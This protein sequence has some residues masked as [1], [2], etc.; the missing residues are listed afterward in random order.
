MTEKKVLVV[1]DEES[2]REALEEFLQGE[3]YTVSLAADGK[4]ALEM[5]S[6][7][8]YT[9]VFMDIKMPGIDGIQTLRRMKKSKPGVKVIVITGLP[10]EKTLER[11]M[12]VSE[13]AVEG[14]IPKPFKPC[15][16]RQAL[17]SLAQGKALPS[18]GLT[19]KQLEVL[20]RVAK[21]GAENASQAL[22]RIT[23]KE[24]KVAAHTA[25]VSSIAASRRPRESEYPAAGILLR[26][27]GD[28]SGG[29]A[30]ILS[31]ESGQRLA[32]ILVKRGSKT[33]E[34]FDEKARTILET[35]GNVIATSF[36]VAIEK[37]LG[38][39]TSA[40]PCGLSFE[41]EA[42]ILEN[43]AR[44]FTGECEHSVVLEMEFAVMGADVS[45][46]II[47]MPDMD[48]LKAIFRQAG[49]FQPA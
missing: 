34:A 10:D 18:F 28:I 47:L 25:K 31:W 3:G 8:D 40:S 24:T 44:K 27:A 4:K 45:G 20:S 7:A 22:S 13:G 35:A 46:K 17:E 21:A 11:A 23:K 9:L 48:S 36:L 37:H 43:A 15:D 14:F 38:L 19:E 33:A 26:C 39:K 49:A 12:A 29:L 41:D 32:G 42:I 30:V 1:D 6:E 2:I 5:F 16:L